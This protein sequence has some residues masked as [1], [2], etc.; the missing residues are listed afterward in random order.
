MNK[1]VLTWSLGAVA[2]YFSVLILSG[3]ARYLRFRRVRPTAIV[4]WP[5]PR[6]AYVLL[7]LGALAL[8]VAV[9]NW[10]HAFHEVY[11]QLSIA[12]YFIGVLPLLARIRMGF[13]GEGIWTEGGFLPYGQIRRLAFRESPSLV[14]VLL[15]RGT[16]AAVRLP[17]PPA[18]YGAV[19]RVL[20]DK[21]RSHSLNLEER[22]LGL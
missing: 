21:I 2:V 10:D 9:L 3:L 20:G 11:S 7:F 16:E 4:T 1:T 5:G 15:P 13:Y 14:L 22:I 19:R 12:L 18:E 8:P 6:P 17:V